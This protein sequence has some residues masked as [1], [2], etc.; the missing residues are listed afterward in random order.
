MIKHPNGFLIKLLKTFK[1]GARIRLHVW[2]KDTERL[3]TP[4]DHRTWFI[5]LPLWGRFEERRY[6]ETAGDLTVLRC[7]STSGNGAPITTPIGKGGV[8]EVSRHRRWPLVPYFCGSDVIHAFVPVG[9][10]GATLVFFGTPR[11]IPRAWVSD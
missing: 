11:K 1:N 10:R 3:A 8:R 6:R 2:P 5:S 7:H 9:R 4:H